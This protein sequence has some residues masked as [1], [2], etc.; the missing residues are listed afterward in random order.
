MR[1]EADRS[2]GFA[3]RALFLGAAQLAV[4][5]GLAARLYHL[6]VD[7]GTEY[8]LLAEDNRANQRLIVPPRGRILDRRGRPL[9]RNV[10]VYRIRV[11]RERARDLADVLRRL[12]DLVALPPGRIDEVLAQAQARP[13]FVPITLRENLS[14]DEVTRIAIR[15]PELPGVELDSA[16]LRDYPHGDVLAHVLGYVGAVSEAELKADP[17]PLLQ[18]PDFRIGKNGV[19]RSYERQLRGRA[20]LSRVEVNAIG[21]EIRELDRKEGEPGTDLRLSLDLDLQRF[22]HARLAGELSASA[23]VLDVR[24]GAVLAL[25]SV[26]SFEPAAFTGRLPVGTWGELRANPRTPLVNKCVRGQYPPG[27]TFKLMTALAALEGGISPTMQVSCSGS[28]YLG[29]AQFHCWKEH[30]HGRLGLVQAIEQSCDV[31]FY[32]LARRVGV[33]A[34]AAMAGRFGLGQPVGI[35]LPGE[36]PGLIPTTAWKKATFKEGWHK[37]ETLVCGIGQGYVLATPLQLAVMTARLANGGLAVTPRLVGAQAAGGEAAPDAPPP[38]LGV[39]QASLDLVLRGMRDVVHGPRGT[40]RAA[41]LGL[42]GVEVGGK[43][44]TSQVRRISKADRLA[45]RHKRKDIPW[46][47]RDHALFVAFAPFAAPRYAV[48]VVVEHGV[49]GAKTAAPIARD[50]LRQAIELDPAGGAPPPI[51]V[52]ASATG[53]PT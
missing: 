19:E 21:R 39:A 42:P 40:A 9:A 32:E 7:R 18:Q 1:Q 33:D 11:I 53:E 46:E 41:A 38:P 51:G 24:T 37:G 27:S 14:W 47:E 26:P 17:D 12:A 29:N 28:V 6:Q 20:G 13:A 44:G 50:I 16:L 15:S 5:G 34:I 31:Y 2:R 49:S 22:C 3:R 4:F 52:V 45:G 43:T 35:D 36:Q 8:A 23:V 48:A 30:G 10:P 25:A